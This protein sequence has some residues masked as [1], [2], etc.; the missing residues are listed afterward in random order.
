MWEI[1]IETPCNMNAAFICATKTA[2]FTIH[3]KANSKS[4]RKYNRYPP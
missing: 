4:W 1:V 2:N 3:Y